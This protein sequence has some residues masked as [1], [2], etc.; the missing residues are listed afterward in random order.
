MQRT[1][2]IIL[3]FSIFL[4]GCGIVSSERVPCPKTAI[5]AE[6]SKSVERHQGILIRT[7]L[8]SLKPECTQED[9]LKNV[10]FR[11]RMTSFRPLGSFRTPM[12]IKPSYFIAVMDKEGNILSRSDHELEIVFEENQTT[13]VSFISVEEQVPA[14]KDVTIYV[15]FNLGKAQIQQ[16]Q[17]EREKSLHDSRSQSH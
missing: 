2:G 16:L 5:L 10:N 14:Q 13:K 8:D 17:K 4:T 7:D 3:S 15:G 1:F 12:T 9:K 11:L 6:F